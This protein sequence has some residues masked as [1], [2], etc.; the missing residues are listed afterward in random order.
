MFENKANML[1]AALSL[2]LSQIDN[3]NKTLTAP[4]ELDLRLE[5]AQSI[6]LMSAILDKW[7]Q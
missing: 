4:I 1:S 2:L 5:V 3:S 7:D 6:L